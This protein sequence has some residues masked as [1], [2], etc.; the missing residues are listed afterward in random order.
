M[1]LDSR[2]FRNALGRFATGVCVI[3]THPEGGN[4]MGMT[5]NSFASVSLEPALVL[6]SLQNNSEC[7][8]MFNGA[9][10]WAVNILAHDQLALSNQYAKKGQHDLDRNHYRIGVTGAPVLRGA[11]TSFECCAWQN[12]DGGDHRVLIGKVESMS[13][14]PTGRPLLFFS[15]RYGELR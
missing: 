2:E 12:Y 15:G 9:R 10:H 11:L 7:F 13:T 6:W 3:T 8:P 4:P 14:R 5:V 1:S